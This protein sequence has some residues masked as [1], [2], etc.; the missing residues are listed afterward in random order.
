ME[1][2]AYSSTPPG[3]N[4]TILLKMKSDEDL[5]LIITLVIILFSKQFKN[6]FECSLPNIVIEI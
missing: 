1:K 2:S 6:I 3:C 5:L 4:I